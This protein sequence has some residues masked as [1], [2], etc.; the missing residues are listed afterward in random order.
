MKNNFYKTLKFLTKIALSVI[1]VSLFSNN[2]HAQNGIIDLTKAD[3]TK[4][5]SISGNWEFY[6]SELLT[7]KEIRTRKTIPDYIK[8]NNVWNGYNYHGKIL[9][10]DGYATFRVKILLPKPGKY[11]LKFHQILSSYNVWINGKFKESIGKVGKNKESSVAHVKANELLFTTN[12]DTVELV[13]Q[14]SNYH[15]LI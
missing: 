1:L 5:N 14:V 10:G 6:W 9:K 12:S 7:P 13:I 3:F 2:V 4:L 11:S 8:I 15:H